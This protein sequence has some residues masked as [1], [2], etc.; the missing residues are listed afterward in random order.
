[1]SAA[2]I[3]LHDSD[4]VVIAI[5]DL[6]PGDALAPS[7]GAASTRVPRGH[8]AALT[9]IATGEKV[10][11]YGQTIGVASRDIAAGEHMHVHNVSM[12]EFDRDYAFSQ[13]ARPTEMVAEADRATFQG[14]RR[15][16]GKAGTR[17]YV[18]IVT[19]VNCSA[20]AARLIAKEAE[21]RGLLDAYPNVDGIVPIVHGAGCCIGTD[22]E[23]FY[24]LQRTIWGFATHP[25]FASVLMLGL[26]CEANQI[27]LML[28]VYGNPPPEQFRYFTLQSQGGTRKTVEDGI[29][30]LEDALAY[31]NQ[32]Q[33]ETVPASELTLALQCGGS[34]GLSGVTA[35]PALGV[36]VDMLVRNGGA[37][38]LA[39]TPEIY[40]AE[41]LLTSRA[42]TPEVGEKLIDLIKWWEGYAAKHGSEMNNN[43]TPGNKAGGLTTILEKSL[44][45]VAKAGSTNLTGVY[46][47]GEPI[48]TRGLVFVDSPGYDPV[49]ITGE[50]ASGCNVVCFT[51]GRGSCYGNKPA[52]SIKIASNTPMYEHMSEDMDLNCGTIADGAETVEQAG[53]RIFQEIL[54]VAS[55][56]KTLSEELGIGDAE[57]APWQTYAQM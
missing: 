16:D 6:E 17:N 11:K 51:T 36:A 49:S 40:G 42:E 21:K 43:P 54:D 19:S 50:V 4:N 48:R 9:P 55:G 15:P 33:R 27:P 10:V 39:E 44:G 3:R 56:K 31:A 26:G 45:A 13:H 7:D 53:H 14:Y 25:N 12:S 28:E 41:H 20:T 47:Y 2:T 24:K 29:R 23:A 37:A 57:F 52:P 35:N 34:D 32:A 1:M 18:G 30:W 46:K 5:T 8:K 38:A 22:D